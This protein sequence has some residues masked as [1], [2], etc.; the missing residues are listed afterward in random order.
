MGLIMDLT[1]FTKLKVHAEVRLAS[2]KASKKIIANHSQYESA[3]L[4][5]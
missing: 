5:A 4:A 1:G 3:A 2:K